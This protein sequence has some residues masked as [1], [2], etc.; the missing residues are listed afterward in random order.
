[1]KKSIK[2]LSDLKIAFDS[3][4]NQMHIVDWNIAI[5][6]LKVSF[7]NIKKSLGFT[8]INIGGLALSLSVCLM[9]II[10]IK[11]QKDVDRFHTKKDRIVQVYTNY[12]DSAS[13]EVFCHASTPGPLAPGILK[14]I[15]FIE[16]AVRLRETSVSISYKEEAFS[17]IG[18]FAEPSF[19]KIFSFHLSSGSIT[20]ALDKPFSVVISEKIAIKLFGNSDPMN[21]SIQVGRL[22]IFTV[23]GVLK[24]EERKSHIQ[25]DVL[26]SFNTISSLE[27][28]GLMESSLNSATNFM[29]YHTYLLLKNENDYKLLNNE[30]PKI[31]DIIIPES[32]RMSIQFDSQKLGDIVSGVKQYNNLSGVKDTSELV[33]L[34]YLAIVIILLACFNYIILSIAHSLKRSK[35]SIL[36]KVM[37]ASRAQITSLFLSETFILVFIAI[38]I[39]G[40]LMIWLIPG[41]NGLD[42]IEKASKQIN[43]EQLGEPG[44][45]LIFIIFFF[46]V[47]ILAGL[48][49]SLYLSSFSKDRVLQDLSKLNKLHRFVTRKLLMSLQFAISL[50]S[51]I[52]II[53]FF[54]LISF[55]IKYDYG[56]N[57][58]NLVHVNIK[59]V[60][61][62][63]FKY[64]LS[65]NTNIYK[66][67]FSSNIPIYGGMQSEKLRNEK[68]DIE[69]YV[70]NYSIDPEFLSNFQL[71]VIA[72]R[73]FSE[74]LPTDKD[75]SVLI[76]E[77]AVQFFG[78]DNPEAAIGQS[79]Y[80]SNGKQV[81]II[82]VIRD[83][84]Y[85]FPDVPIGPMFMTYK[86]EQLRF[87]NIQY[88]Q[89][90]K[91]QVKAFI[92]ETWK[93]MNKID[94]VNYRF[95]DDAID[96]GMAELKDPMYLMFGVCVFIVIIATLGLLGMASYTT[97][98]RIKE[99]GIRKVL[100]ISNWSAVYLL[101][102]D[103]LKLILITSLVAIPSAYFLTQTIFQDFENRPELSLWVLPA[104]LFLFII[105]AVI[106]IGS[107][108]IRVVLTNPVEILR[109][110]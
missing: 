75:S 74:L 54:Q 73:N 83:F 72:G 70:Y 66:I 12:R 110:E 91:D 3:K 13:S 59:N 39:S 107:Q 64:E 34:P 80:K 95:T 92:A 61:R 68:G 104:V 23:T 88:V 65:K 63:V 37:G 27:M 48:Y 71:K 99:I 60:D 101:S 45:L 81:V 29:N 49:P 4:I 7:R 67:S 25:F 44:T 31:A 17:V 30:L 11:D 14:S 42:T 10:Y 1:M 86:P 53:Y 108:T 26:I 21:Q 9:I 40:L 102:K 8:A 94:E 57:N 105:L 33:F 77:K 35:E 43:I 32:K 47:C 62:E 85:T 20:S 51:I 52:F 41:F 24:P 22:G 84:C 38:I 16:D 98:V 6:N 78:F 103:Y 2:K 46:G 55:W 97:E 100:G 87:A 58:E 76:N 19:F 106:T 69:K 93:K 96:E 28:N 50:I 79:L 56:I 15:P 89:G 82:G 90:K 5:N 109:N 18:L 36:R